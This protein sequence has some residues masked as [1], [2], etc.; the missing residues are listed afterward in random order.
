M[1]VALIVTTYERP[2]ALARV[3]ASVA[4][5]S[6]PPDEVGI[7]DDGSGPETAAVVRDHAARAAWPVH[8]AWQRHEGFRVAQARNAAVAR[9]S[10]DY[11]VLIDGDMVLDRDFLADHAAAARPGCWVQGCRLALSAA[12]SASVLAGD[13][14]STHRPALDWRHRVQAVRRPAAARRLCS[15]APALLAVKACNQGV[16][17][18]D[19]V[20]VNGYDEEFVGWGA[21]DKDLAARL[22]NAGVRRRGL[23]FAA[24]AWHLWHSP[25]ARDAAAR[26]A[27]RYAAARATGRVR[28]KT[29]LDRHPATG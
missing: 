21:E 17:R 28:C 4:G 22:A 27:A 13:E 10:A 3:L 6:R 12:A 8:H 26:N 16:W 15:L 9:T 2:D 29:G 7:A 25:A 5:Q 11:L 20:A 1:R 18:C 14:P 23:L 24:L 19:F